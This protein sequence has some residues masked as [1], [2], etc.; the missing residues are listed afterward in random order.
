MLARHILI[1]GPCTN[2]PSNWIIFT[3]LHI[4]RSTIFIRFPDKD[5]SIFLLHF[6]QNL[7]HTIL[8]GTGAGNK[9]RLINVKESCKLKEMMFV[10]FCLHYTLSQVV[11]QTRAFVRKGNNSSTHITGILDVFCPLED[12]LTA[13]LHV[14]H[15]VCMLYNYRY[16]IHPLRYERFASCKA[17]RKIHS[18]TRKLIPSAFYHNA[19]M[20]QTCIRTAN[21]QPLIPPL[22]WYQVDKETQLSSTRYTW[23]G[24]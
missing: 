19:E 18:K 13:T 10:T 3:C 24:S 7:A 23:L 5:V 11:T 2:L 12:L 4:A 16:G 9:R 8:F 1:K 17:C 21:H 15:F 14:E 6:I 20:H 22:I